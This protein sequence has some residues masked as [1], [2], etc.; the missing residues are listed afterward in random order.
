MFNAVSHNCPASGTALSLFSLCADRVR[1]RGYPTLSQVRTLS[2][3]SV[4]LLT[5]YPVCIRCGALKFELVSSQHHRPHPT[6]GWG[7]CSRTHGE[8][9][10]MTRLERAC[11]D[12]RRGIGAV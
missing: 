6:A 10:H 11:Q 12:G 9:D 2:P 5:H 7:R 8:G 3:P 4:H 1:S